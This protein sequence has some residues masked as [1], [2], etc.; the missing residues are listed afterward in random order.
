MRSSAGSTVKTVGLFVALGAT[1]A[2]LIEKRAVAETPLAEMQP[3]EAPA[4]VVAAVIAE[5]ETAAVPARRLT[6]SA[7]FNAGGLLLAI[8]A[9]VFWAMF[10]R[11]QSLGG[12]AA[13]VLVSGKS[14]LPRYHTGDLVL[15]EH[16][17]QYHVGELIA[18]RV[19]KGDPMAGSQVIHRI[20]GG[21]AEHG[22]IVKGDNR[23]A[24]D[25]WRPKPADIVGAKAMRFPQAV[26][27]LQFLRSPVLLA[28]LAGCLVFVRVLGFGGKDEKQQTDDLFLAE[29]A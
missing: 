16:K 8:A 22:F 12:P 24:P 14:M 2:L 29:A 18:Y 9:I 4:P 28:L 23:T 10:L 27:L 19:P 11:P 13:Y 20:I 7:V 1:A 3:V 25:V 21:D 5:P 6:L 26:V 15:V 17:S